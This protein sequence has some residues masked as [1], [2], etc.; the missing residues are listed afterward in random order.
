[1]GSPGYGKESTTEAGNTKI[2]TLP[3]MT[4]I[5]LI[6]TDQKNQAET[7]ADTECGEEIGEKIKVQTSP[8]MTLTGKIG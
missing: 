2:Q 6:Y 3:L 5:T 4:L 7:T 8:L 1:M